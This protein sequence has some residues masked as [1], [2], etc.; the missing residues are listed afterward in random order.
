MSRSIAHLAQFNELRG[1]WHTFATTGALF[2]EQ[3]DRLA[4]INTRDGIFPDL[5]PALWAAGAHATP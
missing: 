1:F 4:E 2:P 3:A 5:D